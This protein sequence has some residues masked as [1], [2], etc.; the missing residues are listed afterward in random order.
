M[1]VVA[2]ARMVRACFVQTTMEQK[3]Q[4]DMT[5][6]IRVFQLIANLKG[7]SSVYWEMRIFEKNDLRYYLNIYIKKN[8]I[9]LIWQPCQW[10]F[11]PEMPFDRHQR[12]S[13]RRTSVLVICG[14]GKLLT[15]APAVLRLNWVSWVL[16]ITEV[17]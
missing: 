17:E 6:I 4:S 16:G 7:N 10:T 5:L 3:S 13:K 8:N 15:S 1:A 9:L 2:K 12:N 14:D 11:E